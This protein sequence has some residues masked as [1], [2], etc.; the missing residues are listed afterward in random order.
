MHANVSNAAVQAYIFK[1]NDQVVQ[2]TG[3]DT[4]TFKETTPGNYKLSAQVVTD[5]G[6]SQVGNCVMDI[7]VETQ[8]VV[9]CS[10]LSVIQLSRTEFKLS[11]VGFTSG[12]ASIKSFDLVHDDHVLGTSENGQ[13]T[14]KR[15]IV[16]D[17][18]VK[19]YVNG[20]RNGENVRLTSDACSA[21]ITVHPEDIPPAVHA[22][23]GLNITQHSQ[24]RFSFAP[25]FTP[26][27]HVKN[28][29]YLVNS[30]EMQ[31]GSTATLN[32]TASK[33]GSYSIKLIAT[34]MQDD[35]KTTEITCVANVFIDNQPGAVLGHVDT[36][37]QLP[38][39]GISSLLPLLAS[40]LAISFVYGS[41]LVADH[42][43]TRQFKA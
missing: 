7:V 4:Y 29:R 34:V 11:A 19:A 31:N 6:T 2:Q 38:N 9:A 24:Y 35:N 16:G 15:D 20:V 1:V 26:N 39:T 25:S 5:K 21:T 22:C 40:I 3:S 8:P 41:H 28:Y 43:Y 32:W 18:Q 30:K 14:L 23:T 36:P 37:P 17:Y 13:F 27:T 12:N 42:L 33:A 10:S